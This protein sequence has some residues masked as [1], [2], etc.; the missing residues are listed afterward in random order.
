MAEALE[1][2]KLIGLSMVIHAGVL[3]FGVDVGEDE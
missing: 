2:I 3:F 1:W